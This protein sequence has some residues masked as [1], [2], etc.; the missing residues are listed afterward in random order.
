[1]NEAAFLENAGKYKDTIYKIAV[2]YLRNAQDADDIVQEVLLKLYMSNQQFESDEHIRNW[3]IRVAINLCKNA[4][5]A[6]WRR[7]NVPLA[8]LSDSISFEQEEQSELFMSVMSLP[9]KNRIV[10]YLFYYEEFSV[11]EIA[12]MLRLKESAVTSR[13]SRARNQLKLKLTE[14]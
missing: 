7:K 9:E 11:K 10:L 13:L 1:M 14:A 8:E 5:R 12:N 3:L 2:N 4:L 6:P